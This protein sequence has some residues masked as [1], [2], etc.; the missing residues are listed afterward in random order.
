VK[1]IFPAEIFP[2]FVWDR[3]RCVQRYDPERLETYFAKDL[4]KVK[5][6]GFSLDRVLIVEDT[7]Q[8]VERNYGNAI[9]VCPFYGDP[10][11]SELPKLGRYL[12]SLATVPNVRCIE[13]RGWRTRV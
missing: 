3:E 12:R 10:N 5:R 7:P 11:D 2:A 4:K 13:K 8:K 9:Y 6:M 1:A